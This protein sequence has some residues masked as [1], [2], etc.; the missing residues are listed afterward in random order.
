[1]ENLAIV[2]PMDRFKYFEFTALILYMSFPIVLRPRLKTN[3]GTSHVRMPEK[4]NVGINSKK[5]M[6]FDKKEV[7]SYNVLSI[8]RRYP[9]QVLSIKFV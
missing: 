9:L 8:D 4:K 2:F 1:M 6:V 7:Y 3:G 5:I